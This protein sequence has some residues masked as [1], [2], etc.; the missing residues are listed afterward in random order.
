MY[1]RYLSYIIRH[2][3]WLFVSGVRY[4]APLWRIIIHDLS[5]L[6]PSEFFPYAVYFYGKAPTG[7]PAGSMDRPN[8]AAN[9]ADEKAR[10]RAAFDR[11]W[12]LHQHRSPHHWQ[13]WVLRNDDG[14]TRALPMPD[15]FIREMVADWAGAGRTIT[16]TWEVY[17]WYKKNAEKMLLHHDT[18]ARVHELLGVPHGVVGSDG[19]D[20]TAI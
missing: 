2:K 14:G 6:T 18:R 12:L 3:W 5:K 16:G 17:E 13:F 10:R 20:H 4:G 11:A 15:H 1:R 19:R 7:V 8:V 9:I